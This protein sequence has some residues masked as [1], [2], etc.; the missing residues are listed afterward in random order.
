VEQTVIELFQINIG[1][2]FQ[3]VDKKHFSNKKEGQTWIEL[4]DKT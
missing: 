2:D 1:S 3:C 4:A